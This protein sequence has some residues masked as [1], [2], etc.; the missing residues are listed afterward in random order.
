METTEAAAEG[1]WSFR[2]LARKGHW[3]LRIEIFYFITGPTAIDGLIQIHCGLKF[4]YY[5][6][7]W[8]PLLWSGSPIYITLA[9]K[10]WPCLFS[11]SL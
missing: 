5:H 10:F 1:R 4:N 7:L 3:R 2:P 9:L 6:L 8:D 11:L